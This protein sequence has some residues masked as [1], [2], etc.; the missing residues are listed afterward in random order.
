MEILKSQ[1][2]LNVGTWALTQNVQGFELDHLES[3]YSP[4]SYKRATMDQ[5]FAPS[6]LIG[7]MLHAAAQHPL[8]FCDLQLKPFSVQ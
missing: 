2:R 7:N 3:Q 4:L 5:V 8:S 1:T 6:C